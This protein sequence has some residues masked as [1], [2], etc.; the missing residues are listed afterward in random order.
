MQYLLLIY[1]KE[2]ELGR[3][4]AD[5][6]KKLTAEYGAFTQ[7]IIQSGHFK[8]GDGLQPSTTATTVRVRDGKILTT[9]GPFAETHEQLGGYYL[10]DAKDLD[11]ALGVAARIPGAKTGSIEVRPI[12]IYD[13]N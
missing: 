1:R 11:T 8:A 12:M 13:N 3:M 7:S 5:D 6:R 10:I 9:D 4:T 2:A